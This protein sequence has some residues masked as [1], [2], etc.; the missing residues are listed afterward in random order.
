MRF[1]I[2]LIGGKTSYMARKTLDFD[3]FIAERENAKMT[4]RIFGRDCVVP[5]ELPFDYMLKVERMIREKIPITGEENF[6][7]LKQLFSAE[8]LEFIVHHPEFRASYI[9][10]LIAFAWLRVEEEKKPSEPVFK[11]EDDVK[12]EET[13]AR[14]AKK[15]RSAR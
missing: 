10:E 5:A 7:L 8:D 14:S 6:A 15:Q 4:I 1:F 2:A 9:W 13:R 11:T 12:V 3:H